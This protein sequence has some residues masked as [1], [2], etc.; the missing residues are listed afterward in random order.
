M[1]SPKI[2]NGFLTVYSNEIDVQ[3]WIDLIN[4]IDKSCYPFERVERRPHETMMLP[5]FFCKT[6]SVEAI[7][8]RNLFLGVLGKYMDK[9]ILD[10][11]ITSLEPYQQFI[12]ISR[13]SPYQSMGAHRDTQ[14]ENS[15]GFIIM[16]YINDDYV[17]GELSFPEKN[18]IY[19]PAAGDIAIYPMREPHAV[20][21]TTLGI[22]YTIGCGFKSPIA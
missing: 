20:E 8:L 14:D 17:N 7:E 3:H 19:K 9:Y 5:N 15:K 11:E 2:D 6:D 16:L 4:K 18:Y 12:A 22:R 1:Q 21:H 13:L 10:H